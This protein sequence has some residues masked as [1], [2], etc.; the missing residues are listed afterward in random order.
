MIHGQQCLNEYSG[1]MCQYP[2]SWKGSTSPS[3][4]HGPFMSI[5]NNAFGHINFRHSLFRDE[6]DFNY[7]KDID[8]RAKV[9]KDK[10]NVGDTVFFYS[11]KDEI[12][13]GVIKKENPTKAKIVVSES[14]GMLLGGS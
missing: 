1:S 3:T 13:K 11:E 2:G 4:G 5:L 12:I 8:E 14:Y 6:E 7:F 9:M 10:L